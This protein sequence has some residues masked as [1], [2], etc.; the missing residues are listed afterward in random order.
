LF[1]LRKTDDPARAAANAVANRVE[2]SGHR[3]ERDETVFAIIAPLE[4]E[5]RPTPILRLAQTAIHVRWRS[6]RRVKLN[7]HALLQQQKRG[8]SFG[9][10][11]EIEPEQ[12][13][14]LDEDEARRQASPA[15][16]DRR[17]PGERRARGKRK[18]V[19]ELETLAPKP[20]LRY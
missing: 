6:S 20:P 10:A 2:P 14:P 15:P 8:R 19:P 11:Q 18:T 5:Q 12:R 4:C 13:G 1:A 9:A 3:N 16:G 17:D 7:L